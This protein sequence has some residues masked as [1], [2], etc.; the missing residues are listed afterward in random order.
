MGIRGAG[1]KGCSKILGW[2]GTG[3]LIIKIGCGG[4]LLYYNLERTPKWYW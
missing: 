4:V 1:K 3:A 2:I